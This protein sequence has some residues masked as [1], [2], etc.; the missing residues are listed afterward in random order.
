MHQFVRTEM[1]LGKAAMDKLRRAHVAV[2]GIGGVGS[3]AAEAL[4]RS[5]VGALSLFD[6]DVVSESNLNRQLIALHSTLG[7]KKVD[8]M[9]RR[10][11][12][13]NPAA[14]VRAHAM[15][16]TPENAHEVDLRQFDCVIDAIDTVSGKIALIVG[17]QAAGVPIISCMGAGNKLDPTAFRVGD[18][19][20][21]SGCPLARVLRREL[22][23]R[24]VAALRV[25][26]SRELAKTP[27]PLADDAPGKRCTPGSVAFVPSV[28]GLAAAGEAI[29]ML[30]DDT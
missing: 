7:Q 15:F 21:T 26:Y 13:I 2:F 3:F 27:L 5:G 1:L 28:A 12:D 18:L 9:A 4:A 8:V 16:V 22:R 6:H 30:T 14:T 24:G 11:A 29:R 25:V 17:A 20:E 10:I 19:Y 23:A